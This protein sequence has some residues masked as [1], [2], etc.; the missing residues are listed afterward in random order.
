M[1]RKKVTFLNKESQKSSK[2]SE[3]IFLALPF[4][5]KKKHKTRRERERRKVPLMILEAVEYK[6]SKV[7]YIPIF[8]SKG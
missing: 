1:R 5:N 6:T 3:F 2:L 8:H 4:H 7:C